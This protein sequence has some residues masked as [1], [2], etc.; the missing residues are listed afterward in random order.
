MAGYILIVKRPVLVSKSN[1]NSSK[2]F[3]CK[4]Q[5]VTVFFG[6]VIIRN[7]KITK[8]PE[9][10]VKGRHPVHTKSVNYHYRGKVSAV[11]I[12]SCG[13]ITDEYSREGRLWEVQRDQGSNL[14]EIT[15]VLRT[16]SVCQCLRKS[17]YMCVHVDVH[18][19][20]P[21]IKTHQSKG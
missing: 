17:V 1:D 9:T 15:S 6:G 19:S 2:V 8:K 4:V 13:N 7:I 20:V 10:F 11:S 3:Y 12:S 16:E 21:A 14:N 5:A 18:S